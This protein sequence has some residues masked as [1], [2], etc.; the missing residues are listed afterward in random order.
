MAGAFFVQCT[1]AVLEE[2]AIA[3]VVFYERPPGP[4]F[5]R[6]L[7]FEIRNAD[8]K[9]CGHRLN[10]VGVDPDITRRPGA[11]IAAFGAVK[12]Q[13]SLGIPGLGF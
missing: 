7:G 11:A 1:F 10:L 8:F 3:V 9:P 4:N 13:P 2:D 6:E 5:A 12:F